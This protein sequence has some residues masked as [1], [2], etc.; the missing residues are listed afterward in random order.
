MRSFFLCAVL[1]TLAVCAYS[2]PAP[3]SDEMPDLEHFTPDQVDKA[4]DPC[5][6][7]FQY[8]CSKWVK[9]N[10]IPA[11]QAGW[12]TF[13]KLAIWNVAAIHNTLEQAASPGG[14]K[15][16]IEKKVGDYYSS[17]IDETTIAKDGIAPLKPLLDRLA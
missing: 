13:N 4:L 11:D 8:A 2:Q 7:F 10:P 16:P 1:L 3:P 15:S 6:D 9:A 12:G 5:T 17:C 14:N